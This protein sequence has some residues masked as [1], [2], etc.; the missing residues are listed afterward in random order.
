MPTTVDRNAYSSSTHVALMAA[1]LAEGGAPVAAT[2]T[3]QGSALQ[4]TLRGVGYSLTPSALVRQP[5]P[6]AP[7]K[8]ANAYSVLYGSKLGAVDALVVADDGRVFESIAAY[9]ADGS[10]LCD[11]ADADPRA[12]I[13][14]RLLAAVPA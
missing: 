4:C 1:L 14:A 12:A 3:A 2:F 8:T 9:E 13:V 7:E 5:Q 10:P 11:L 6:T